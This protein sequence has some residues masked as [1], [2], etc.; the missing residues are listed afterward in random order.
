MRSSTCEEVQGQHLYSLF[1][2]AVEVARRL[3]CFCS[4]PRPQIF[5]ILVPS[6]LLFLKGPIDA[7]LL[8]WKWLIHTSINLR[9]S[10]TISCGIWGTRSFA[11]G[12]W[13]GKNWNCV[14]TTNMNDIFLFRK[15]AQGLYWLS[16]SCR[17]SARTSLWRCFAGRQRIQMSYSNRGCGRST[18][19]RWTRERSRQT[20]CCK[21]PTIFTRRTILVNSCSFLFYFSFFLF[22]ITYQTK[23]QTPERKKKRYFWLSMGLHWCASVKW[24]LYSERQKLLRFTL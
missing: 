6:L 13:K 5:F 15:L 7:A 3:L 17:F 2:G 22:S 24:D 18:T 11:S 19:M 20:R 12:T 14:S 23:K 16:C 21:T 10:G 9:W 8:L 1:K 4:L